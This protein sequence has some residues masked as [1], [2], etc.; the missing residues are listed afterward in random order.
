MFEIDCDPAC[1]FMV[2]DHDKSEAIKMAIT[3]MKDTH[4]KDV[5]EE[6]ASE[7]VKMVD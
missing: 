4:G 3:H 2:K 5:S 6:E 7:L 1:G